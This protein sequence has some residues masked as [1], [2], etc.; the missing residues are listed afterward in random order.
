LAHI[1]RDQ[2]G[3]QPHERKIDA[4]AAIIAE[5]L[6]PQ[7]RLSLQRLSGGG[8]N[9]LYR[10]RDTDTTEEYALKLYAP[11][12]ADRADAAG[13]L[14][15]EINGLAFLS[16]RLPG[17]VP[18]AIGADEQELA[19]IYQ[20]ISGER[21]AQT[22]P[23]QRPSAW[24]EMMSLFV[25]ALSHLSQRPDAR[26]SIRDTAR[27]ACLSSD[28]LLQQIKRRVVALQALPQEAALQDLLSAHF[29]PILATASQRL[30]DAYAISGRPMTAEIP[31]HQQI[32]SPSDFGLHNALVRADGSLVFIDFEYFGWD[33]P[34][35]LLADVVW[36]PGMHFSSIERRAFTQHCLD[37]LAQADP[38]LVGRYLAQLPL[39]GLR[40]A[41][42]QLNEFVPERWRRR[43]FAGAGEADP[44]AWLAAKDRQLMAATRTI[45]AAEAQIARLPKIDHATKTSDTALVMALLDF[46][47]Q[48][49]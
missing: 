3:R 44:S 33:D 22:D 15:R 43:V 46:I 40:W 35:K 29:V 30:Q 45:Q 9:R 42:I 23:A 10:L 25:T 26:R 41:A 38:D 24:I 13:R 37:H 48:Y 34:V 17:C 27:E 8:N 6:L 31:Q 2:A 5:R 47:D 32:L 49:Q 21:T 7:N 16:Q 36:H 11:P 20:W 4:Q 19:A 18:A 39:Y 12:G 14:R 28:S 1:D